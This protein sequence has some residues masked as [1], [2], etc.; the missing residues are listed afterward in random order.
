M[1]NMPVTNMLSGYAVPDLKRDFPFKDKPLIFLVVPEA[2]IELAR[3]CPRRILSPLRLPISP[4]R[5]GFG[6]ISESSLI[7]NK[8]P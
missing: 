6:F 8:E 5:H 3:S 7:V 4:L 1:K 2:R